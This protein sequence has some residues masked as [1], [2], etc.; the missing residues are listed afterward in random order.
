[1]CH[2][3]WADRTAACSKH[4]H[5]FD[6][7]KNSGIG[8]GAEMEA[9]MLSDGTIVDAG[10]VFMRA[11]WYAACQVAS[12]PVVQFAAMLQP[13]QPNVVAPIYV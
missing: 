9:V 1:M 6:E 10:T 11:S 4:S 7:G 13:V 12:A 2:L 8:S 5:G 3:S